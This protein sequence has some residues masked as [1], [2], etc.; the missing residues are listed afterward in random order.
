MDQFVA[1]VSEQWVLFAALIFILVML[2]HSFISAWG[3]TNVAPA[4]A[5]ALM[6]RQ[7]AVVLDVRTDEEFNSGHILHSVHIPVG[8]LSKRL[9]ELTPYKAKP[10]VVTCRTG[11][12]SA[13]ACSM[14]RKAGFDPI[15]RLAGGVVAWQSA[16]LPLTKKP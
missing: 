8:L 16:N 11:Q 7:D 1:F 13:T 14:L 3:V 15:F 12:R 5:I 10:I 4:E 6:N 2:G 9:G